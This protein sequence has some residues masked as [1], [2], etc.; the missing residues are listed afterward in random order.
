VPQELTG[1]LP[2]LLSNQEVSIK[3]APRQAAAEAFAAAVHHP[4][5]TAHPV[6]VGQG[7]PHRLL[8]LP[9]EEDNDNAF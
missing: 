3:E 4:E 1:R 5:V 7:H 6:Q 9:A 8:P 2:L